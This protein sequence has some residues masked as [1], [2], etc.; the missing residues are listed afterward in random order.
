MGTTKGSLVK[1][2]WIAR[3]AAIDHSHPNPRDVEIKK[4]GRYWEQLEEVQIRKRRW[5]YKGNLAE[6][7]KNVT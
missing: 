2:G 4:S 5:K 3:T 1:S 6:S 7:C